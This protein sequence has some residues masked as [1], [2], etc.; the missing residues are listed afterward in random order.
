ML[1]LNAFDSK[2]MS[3]EHRLND[4]DRVKLKYSKENAAYYHF[5]HH[6]FYTDRYGIETSLHGDRTVT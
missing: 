1:K 4:N 2:D 6:G 3:M 5:V